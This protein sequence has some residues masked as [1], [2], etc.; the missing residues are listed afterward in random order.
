MALTN[1][2]AATVEELHHEWWERMRLCAEQQTLTCG[3]AAEAEE[4]QQRCDRCRSYADARDAVEAEL[5]RRGEWVEGNPP[6]HPLIYKAPP[7]M[8]IPMSERKGLG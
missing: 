7:S 3:C 4:T 2:E 1:L 8:N 6:R 5:R